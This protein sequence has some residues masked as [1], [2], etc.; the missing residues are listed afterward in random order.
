MRSKSC[1]FYLS[2]LVTVVVNADS[3]FLKTWT[4]YHSL[5]GGN[6]FVRRGQIRLGVTE[7]DG[8]MSN[9]DSSLE[10]TIEQED[11][12][13][14][15]TESIQP[16]IGSGLYQLKLVEEGNEANVVLTSVPA[17]HLRRANFRYVS[18]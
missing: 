5:D 12:E 8:D 3:A 10:L 16:Y 2:L 6:D 14:L 13:N 17:C 18:R 9:T 11:D 7:A 1:G 15:T 4:M